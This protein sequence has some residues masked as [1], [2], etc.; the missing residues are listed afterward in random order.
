[1]LNHVS[2]K[3]RQS[4][5]ASAAEDKLLM[6]AGVGA[7]GHDLRLGHT[8]HIKGARQCSAPVQQLPPAGTVSAGAVRAAVT[9]ILSRDFLIRCNFAGGCGCCQSCPAALPGGPCHFQGTESGGHALASYRR[10]I[11]IF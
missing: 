5:S 10:Q 1:M 7:S 8:V 2:A 11:T 4:I 6:R 9:V 3:E